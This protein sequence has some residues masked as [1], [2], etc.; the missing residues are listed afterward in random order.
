[1]TWALGIGSFLVATLLTPLVAS[2]AA[3]FGM[4]DAPGA[5]R[6]V[7]GRPVPL[8]GGLAIYL[9]IAVVVALVLTRSPLLTE[10]EVTW[11]HYAGIG[12][13]GLILM[14]GGYLD[15]RYKLRPVL[16]VIFPVAAAIIAILGGLGVE[17][18]TNPFG[19][20]LP[21]E[22]TDWTLG[23]IAGIPV[24]VSWPGDIFVF[25]WLMVVMYTTKLLDGLDGLATS[26]GA[27]G[28]LMILLLASTAAFFQPDMQV[29][30]A[31]V[32]G[33]FLGFLVWNMYP[34]QIFLGEGG[35]L[36][37]GFLLASLAVI[38][39][40]KIATLLLV[41]GVPMLDVV[42]V[43]T[44]RMWT[45][46]AISRGD[47]NHLHH[48]LYDLGLSH[49]QVVSLYTVVALGFGALTLILPSFAKLIALAVLGV[50]MAV[51]AVCLL[52]IEGDE[53]L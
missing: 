18:V 28:A 29:A 4:V 16:Q 21:L 6:K 7:H 48:R 52:M 53:R 14:V 33:A 38:S 9:S 45:G 36:L 43:V 1:M 42:W 44:R 35:A 8:L 39:G 11:L 10:G 37:V 19:G 50:L 25:V 15:D 2:I 24:A 23:T 40:G 26:I 27:V 13:A 49:V 5:P 47:R 34:A 3:R 32:L 31:I 12:L 20:A 30:S 46:K 17:K 41:M 22:A 51:A